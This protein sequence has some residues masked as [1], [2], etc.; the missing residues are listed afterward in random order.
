VWPLE[1]EAVRARVLIEHPDP[2]TQQLLANGLRQHG[3]EALTCSGPRGE[4]GS[5]TSCP[6]LRDAP[7]GGVAGADVVIAGLPWSAPDERLILRRLTEEEP[8]PAILLGPVSD[9]TAA[10]LDDVV[11]DGLVIELSV[12]AVLRALEE[13]ALPPPGPAG[14]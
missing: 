1:R 14:P 11:I 9:Q 12:D 5:H 8:R 2:E 6:L 13:L 10:Q 3:Y 7:C 4:D